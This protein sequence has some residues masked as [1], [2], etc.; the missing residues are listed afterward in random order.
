MTKRFITRNYQPGDF[1]EIEHIWKETGMCGEMRGDTEKTVEDSIAI[2]G[3]LLLLIENETGKIIGTSWMTF[4]GRQ[5]HLH[6]FGISPEY[7]GKGLSKILLKKS[8]K[9]A[10]EKGVQIKLEVHDK[11][12][13]AINLYKNYGF[14]YLGDYDIY[15]IRDLGN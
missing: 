10:K 7:Q 3:N 9:I 15:I 13:K 6:H 1:G 4:D 5:F 8:L 2:G 12:K 11:N 14:S